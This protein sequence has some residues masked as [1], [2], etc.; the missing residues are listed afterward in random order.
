M[1]SFNLLFSLNDISW[2]YSVAAHAIF[3]SFF[4]LPSRRVF[5]YV[6]VPWFIQPVFEL[7]HFMIV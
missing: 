7:Q 6:A 5:H 2:N 4:L 3:L 1:Y